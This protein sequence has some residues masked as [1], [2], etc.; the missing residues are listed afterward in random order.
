M[1]CARRTGVASCWLRHRKNCCSL[2]KRTKSCRIATAAT[3]IADTSWGCEE[4]RDLAR[5]G[6]P[7]E[8]HVLAGV[9][10]LRGHQTRHLTPPPLWAKP[11]IPR[12]PRATRWC[13]TKPISQ[14]KKFYPSEV[15]PAVAQ[16]AA[17]FFSPHPNLLPG[18]E[19]EL[20]I[21]KSTFNIKFLASPASSWFIARKSPITVN[22]S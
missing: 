7:A 6:A 9:G 8:R 21:A 17:G 13:C 22:G 16:A 11:G 10:Q 14:Q 5:V 19:K 18:A 12:A 1:G 15:E 20:A 4:R 3:C 2:S